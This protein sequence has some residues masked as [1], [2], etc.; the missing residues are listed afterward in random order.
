MIYVCCQSRLSGSPW[1]G[2][3]RT[4]YWHYGHVG[5]PR[6]WSTSGAWLR[7]TW[8]GA[9]AK[10]RPKCGCLPVEGEDGD[11]WTDRSLAGSAAGAEAEARFY[12]PLCCSSIQQ[13]VLRTASRNAAHKLDECLRWALVFSCF[14]FLVQVSK[15]LPEGFILKPHDSTWTCTCHHSSC[16]V[17]H[18]I[19]YD[20]IPVVPHKAVAE[21]SKIGNL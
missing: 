6:G 1:P 5:K 21:V 11:C 4:C 18:Y 3:D 7:G 14:P 2:K 10:Q 8:S 12:F 20:W 9:T 17:R 15:A 13:F 16:F 19:T